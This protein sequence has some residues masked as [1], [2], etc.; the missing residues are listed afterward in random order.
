MKKITYEPKSFLNK[1][2]QTIQPGDRIVA[3]AGGRSSFIGTYEGI[4]LGVR[5]EGR[6]AA[7]V[8]RLTEEVRGWVKDGKPCD[9]YTEG[10]EMGRYIR[11][12]QA[13]YWSGR[14]F[15]LAD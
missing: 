2:G 4:F 8:V 5:G 15:K 10:K 9:Y 13:T 14:I 6:K 7:Q 12:R 1:F 3:V 11:T